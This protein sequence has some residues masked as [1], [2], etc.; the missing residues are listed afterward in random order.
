MGTANI[1][2]VTPLLP[3]CSERLY[4][5]I[6]LVRRWSM[7]ILVSIFIFFIISIFGAELSA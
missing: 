6:Q 7:S 1:I 5:Y 2:F 4:L 3:V